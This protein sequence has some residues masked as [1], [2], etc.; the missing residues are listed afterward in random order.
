MNTSKTIAKASILILG[1]TPLSRFLVFM[2]LAGVLGVSLVQIMSLGPPAMNLVIIL[3]SLLGGKWFGVYG[4]AVG[5]VIGSLV[6]VLVQQPAL[7]RIGFKYSLCFDI[8][9]SLLRLDE[10]RYLIGTAYGYL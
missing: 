2:S 3:A 10:L 4:L 7:R 5:G 9:G 6:F 1:P 8:V